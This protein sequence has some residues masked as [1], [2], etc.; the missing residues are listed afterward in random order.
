MSAIKTILRGSI[1][2]RNTSL[3]STLNEKELLA[4]IYDITKSDEIFG[5]Q[6]KPRSNSEYNYYALISLSP[7]LTVRLKPKGIKDMSE[8]EMEISLHFIPK[9][10]L[11]C[12]LGIMLMYMIFSSHVSY[13]TGSSGFFVLIGIPIIYIVS[14]INFWFQSERCKNEFAR[15]IERLELN[16]T[17]TT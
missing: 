4:E 8:L 10:L 16:K 12:V 11:S 15:V 17:Q 3:Y 6:I 5:C 2:L 9:I 1:F 13:S 7:S 14:Q